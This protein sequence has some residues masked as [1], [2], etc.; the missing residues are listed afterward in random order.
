MAVLPLTRG[1]LGAGGFLTLPEWGG[2]SARAEPLNYY[3]EALTPVKA[4]WT[5]S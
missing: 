1:V 3:D 5:A 2:A 4:R